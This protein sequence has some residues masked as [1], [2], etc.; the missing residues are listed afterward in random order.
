MRLLFVGPPGAGKGTQ[1]ER[2]AARLGIA[3]VSTGEMFRAL[4]ETTDLGRRVRAIMAAGEYVSDEIVIEMLEDRIG[5]PDAEAGYILDGFPR[6]TAQAEALDEHLGSNGLDGVVLLE[7]PETEL[8][9]RML[10]RGRS[11]DTEATILNRL[12]VYAEQTAPLLEMYGA[13]GLVRPVDGVGSLDEITER[14]LRVL[15]SE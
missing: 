14:I 1:A 3:H 9:E 4:D 2:V 5:R 13:R 10:G 12:H 6:T 7:A 8:V 15:G 11:D